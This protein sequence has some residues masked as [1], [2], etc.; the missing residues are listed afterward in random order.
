MLFQRIFPQLPPPHPDYKLKLS[1]EDE[2]IS[3]TVQL[4]PAQPASHEH[5]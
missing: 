2:W 4:D 3:L 1:I 5:L